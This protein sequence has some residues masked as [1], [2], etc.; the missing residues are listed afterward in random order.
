MERFFSNI[1]LKHRHQDIMGRGNIPPSKP[2]CCMKRTTFSTVSV[3][4]LKAISLI[5]DFV[6]LAVR[7]AL[8]YYSKNNFVIFTINSQNLQHKAQDPLVHHSIL[9]LVSKATYGSNSHIND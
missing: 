4:N 5:S 6:F 2:F 9:N 3:G 1:P 7:Y 8:Q